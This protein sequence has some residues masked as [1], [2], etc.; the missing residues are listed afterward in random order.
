MK[1]K[2]EPLQIE[3]I[4]EVSDG[5]SRSMLKRTKQST[6]PAASEDDDDDD[7]DDD[8]GGGSEPSIGHSIVSYKDRKNMKFACSACYRA[9]AACDRKTPCSRCIRTGKEDECTERSDVGKS[10]YACLSCYKAKTSCDKMQPCGRCERIGRV[11]VPRS[12]SNLGTELVVNKSRSR[13]VLNSISQK[14]FVHFLLGEMSNFRSFFGLASQ[15]FSEKARVSASINLVSSYLLQFLDD[16]EFRLIMHYFYQR[17]GCPVSLFKFRTQLELIPS[18]K[19]LQRRGR[20]SALPSFGVDTSGPP[21]PSNTFDGPFYNMSKQKINLSISSDDVFAKFIDP[22]LPVALLIWELKG[23]LFP[24]AHITALD[25]KKAKA[26]GKTI[27][28]QAIDGEFWNRLS[29]LEL[30]LH[31][32]KEAERLYGYT[33]AELKTLIQGTI[34]GGRGPAGRFRNSFF[35]LMDPAT[36][37]KFVK[38]DLECFFNVR[39]YYRIRGRVTPKKGP[40][41]ECI[42]SCRYYRDEDGM[43]RLSSCATVPVDEVL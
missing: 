13:L 42:F 3:E 1:R 24:P 11:C 16:G 5:G 4:N 37:T 10:A 28:P 38:A 7:D 27:D 36:A 26:E 35:E 18:A 19:P 33:A 25:E 15:S 8:D 41:L 43:I 21:S 9:K 40:P 2:L 32:N 20:D 34:S 6:S 39:D 22:D 12:R 31:V 14:G 23:D 30:V 17:T 29:G